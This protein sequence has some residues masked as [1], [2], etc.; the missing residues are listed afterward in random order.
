MLLEPC[1]SQ[2][3]RDEVVSFIGPI[4]VSGKVRQVYTEK[5]SHPKLHQHT[6]TTEIKLLLHAHNTLLVLEMCALSRS[7]CINLTVSMR[8]IGTVSQ[9][10][11]SMQTIQCQH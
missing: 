10:Q 5:L 3:M 1:W 8:H 7:P 11:Q 2:D 6:A 4:C 9:R